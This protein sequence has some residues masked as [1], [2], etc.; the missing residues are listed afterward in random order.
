MYIVILI[1]FLSYCTLGHYLLFLKLK[2][3]FWKI[4]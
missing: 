1:F 3:K 2:F 4:D